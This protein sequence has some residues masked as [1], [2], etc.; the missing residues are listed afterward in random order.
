MRWKEEHKC[1]TGKMNALRRPVRL[2]LRQERLVATR[3]PRE[4]LLNLLLTSTL[5]SAGRKDHKCA[6]ANFSP[7]SLSADSSAEQ[8][9]KENHA[10]PTV[11]HVS[12]G[13]HMRANVRSICCICATS[14]PWLGCRPVLVSGDAGDSRNRSTSLQEASHLE[15]ASAPINTASEIRHGRVR[16]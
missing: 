9:S 4:L 6:A 13:W 7:M 1:I 15:Q 16:W 2:P 8:A 14:L 11:V 3:V 10:E 12:F 5:R